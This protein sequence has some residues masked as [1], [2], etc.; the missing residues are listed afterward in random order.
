MNVGIPS[1]FANFFV[2]DQ[3]FNMLTLLNHDWYFG[4]CYAQ[5]YTEYL[6]Y[7]W[8][9]L[10]RGAWLALQQHSKQGISSLN[11]KV[12]VEHLCIYWHESYLYSNRCCLKNKDE[13]SS[14]KL[15]VIFHMVYF[16][17]WI[18]FTGCIFVV[19]IYCLVETCFLIRFPIV[20]FGWLSCFVLIICISCFIYL[21]ILVVWCWY[22]R[23]VFALGYTQ[24]GRNWW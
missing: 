10:V 17:A 23:S 13:V 19:R 21:F 22:I 9:G 3:W 18:S 14:N 16:V 7:I 5:V 4:T 11:H 1:S 24:Q 15:L 6:C 2:L 12:L 8:G 20:L